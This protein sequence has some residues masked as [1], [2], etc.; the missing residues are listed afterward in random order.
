MKNKPEILAP[1]GSLAAGIYAIKAGADAIYTGL[2]RFSA[3]AFA[4]NPSLQELS[5]LRAFSQAQGVKLN[6]AFNTLIRD[7][8]LEEARY[9]LRILSMLRPDAVIVQDLGLA[10]LI[11]K[12]FPNLTLHASTQLAIHNTDG[13]RLM[14]E[15]GFSRV[16]LARELEIAE[17]KEIIQKVPEIEYEVFVSGA[18]C[19]STSG[20]CLA[21]GLMLGRSANRGVC[22]QVCR[23]WQEKDKKKQY[24]FSMR[25]LMLIEHAEELAKTGIRSFKIEG[26]MKSPEYVDAAVRLWRKKLDTR[27]TDP[28]L[29]EK[30]ALSFMR[31]TGEGHIKT[32]KE[33]ELIDT[34]YPGHRGLKLGT[35]KKVAEKEA[36]VH[37]EQEIHI[38]D[39][40]GIIEKGEITAWAIKSIRKNQ[41]KLT[42]AQKGMQVWINIPKKFAEQ[43]E[44]RLLSAH[45]N[46]L[47]EIKASALEKA[48]LH[49]KINITI[50]KDR[51]HI[52][53][54]FADKTLEEEYYH[55]LQ[56]AAEKEITYT[57]LTQLFSYY[58]PA[59]QIP[60][61]AEL[62]INAEDSINITRIFYPPSFLKQ[63]RR[64][65]FSLLYKN[66][67][68]P[69]STQ[70]HSQN[71][72]LNTPSIP[73]RNT[74]SPR[75]SNLPFVTDYTNIDTKSLAKLTIKNKTYTVIPLAPTTFSYKSTYSQLH[76][77][78]EKNPQEN[79]LI[80]LNNPA[81]ILWA[82]HLAT[83]Y[84]Q[85]IAFFTDYLLYN[86][87]HLTENLYKHIIPNLAFSYPWIESP[88][89]HP[90]YTDF[91]PPIFYSRVIHNTKEPLLTQKEKTLTIIHKEN[92]SY[93]LV[94]QKK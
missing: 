61:K 35:I 87:N 7:T 77:I 74:L 28:Q 9:W 78:I 24:T 56:K 6:I 79:F 52:K 80:G 1:A 76:N 54:D 2:P 13:A 48:P 37:L 17:I 69:T 65:I 38:R 70:K 4:N 68:N 32:H 66:L 81:H 36:L 88:V 8:E 82:K 46:K 25:D 64:A 16:I 86:S 14:A 91:N 41:T 34:D 5:A 53:L 85:R 93:T 94:Q 58:S 21:S 26:R 55:S 29:M 22:A 47:P 62:T 50:Y 90:C 30:L 73:L 71:P 67:D 33:Q 45:D 19:Y 27:R 15:L 92:M 60:I 12:D 43:H 23:T 57:K 84:Q 63:T 89:K 72:P 44:I 20:I 83:I 18:M 42:Q 31:N 39:G 40:A 10:D 49:T 11:R 3:R 51:L 75:D 59:G